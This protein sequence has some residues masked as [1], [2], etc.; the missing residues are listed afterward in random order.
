MKKFTIITLVILALLSACGNPFVNNILP[1]KTEN[2]V[3]DSI[4]D[5][6]AWPADP[7]NPTNPA[8]PTDPPEISFIMIKIKSSGNADDDSVT[9][10]PELGNAGDVITLNYKVADA[11]NH[12]RLVF[13]GTKTDIEKVDS[14]GSGTRTYTVNEEDSIEGVITIHAVFAHSDK[15]FDDIAFA[16][17]NNEYRIYGAAAFTKAITNTGKGSGNINYTS[18]D[19]T[20]AAVNI[21]TGEVTIKKV[22]TTDITAT[23]EEDDNYSKAEAVYTLTVTQLQLTKTNPTVTTTKDYDGSAT[24]AITEIG[25]LDNIVDGDD[26][27]V[28]ASAS[29]DSKDAG[30]KQITVVYSISGT[31]ANNYIK[32]VNYTVNGT[33]NKLQLYIANPS[34][35]PSKVYDGTTTAVVTAGALS[36]KIGSD[37][38]TVSAT[39]AYNSANVAEAN[40][41]TVVYSISGAD[42]D[43]YIKPVNF[44]IG[45]SI[46]KAPGSAVSVPKAASKTDNSITIRAV[47]MLLPNLGQTAEYAIAAA[48]TPIP[49]TGWQ[50]N[51]VFS[52]LTKNNNYYFFARS[53]ENANCGA[54]TAQVSAAIK[55]ID[56]SDRKTVINFETDAIGKTYTYTSG[57]NSPS[58]VAVIA[59]PDNSGEKSLQITTGGNGWNQ[60]AVIPVYLPYALSNYGSFSFRFRLLSIGNDTT[61]RE[62]QVYAAGD[63]ATFKRYSFGNPSSSGN[64]FAVNLVGGI[65][66]TLFNDS[67]KNTWTEYEITCSP[68]GTISSLQGN[69]YIAIGMNCNDVR[70]YMLDDLIFLMR[71]DYDAPP[72]ITPTSAVFDKKEGTAANTDITVTMT[73]QGKTLTSITGGSITSSDYIVSDKVVTLLKSYLGNQTIGTTTLIFN[74]SDNTAKTIAI[75]INDS[76]IQTLAYT[77]ANWS[78]LE[79]LNYP[80]FGPASSTSTGNVTGTPAVLE[81][82]IKTKGDVVILPFSL[83]DK[84]LKDFQSI[85][86]TVKRSD[87]DTNTRYKPLVAQIKA[88]PSGTFGSGNSNTTITGSQNNAFGDTNNPNT[89][90]LSL[91]GAGTTSDLSGSIEIA[92]YSND[93][94]GKYQIIEV[95]LNPKP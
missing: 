78:T 60:A 16:D 20:V 1:D 8:K 17:K 42:A 63:T 66:P 34:V 12:N 91:T 26:V 85:T 13:S 75:T 55:A 30:A 18:S 40:Q 81:V 71:D 74:F 5:E 89:F 28:S 94:L 9:A 83:G 36:N 50:E 64:N 32:P 54:G 93:L 27:S 39:G 35:T 19:P 6:P 65:E 87:S 11:N 25:A 61:P 73:L 72:I 79:A 69:I 92:L 4:I 86:F 44:T 38:V 62:I 7:S 70:D 24:A 29:F 43:N 33:I 49:T 10:S 82:E 51:R 2:G 48:A 68:G 57:D 90:T 88:S 84:Q 31:A 41:I 37:V 3:N 14:A 59:D 21:D 23:K 76:A 53:K 52:G 15:D 58:K 46:A 95:R 45:G 77:S 80:R 67:Y 47:T 56:D 22:G